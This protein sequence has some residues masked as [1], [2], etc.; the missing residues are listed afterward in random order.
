MSESVV[1]MQNDNV[2]NDQ[3]LASAALDAANANAVQEVEEYEIEVAEASHGQAKQDQATNRAFA[4]QRIAR[5]R[6][7]ELEEQIEKLK[8]GEVSDELRVKPD[9]PQSPSIDDY[10]SDDALEKYGYDQNKAFAAFNQ[11]NSEWQLKA[12]DAKSVASAKQ[13]QQINQ[14]IGQADQFGSKVRQHYDVAEKLAIPDYSAIEER[15]A[16][17]LPQGWANSVIDMFPDKSAAI[18]AHLDKNPA[19][20]QSLASMNPNIAIVEFTRLADSLTIK[21]KSKLS[22]APQPDEIL[23]AS[24]GAASTIMKQMEQAAKDGNVAKYRELKAQL[25]KR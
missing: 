6:Q 7:K 15:I 2:N 24:G 3:A 21:P 14:F 22:Q 4:A 8:R 17:S 18:F 10:L 25:H 1:E 20:L 12:M 5:K 11:A 16:T 9:L 23:N 13:S 19:K